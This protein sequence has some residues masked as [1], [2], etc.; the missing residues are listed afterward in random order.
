MIKDPNILLCM[1]NT[2]L[3]DFYESLDDL[4][5]DLN[6][7]KNDIIDLL[8]T[9]HYQY[10]EKLNAFVSIEIEQKEFPH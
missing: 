6:I 1:I 9:I 8:K 4:C 7:N 10:D 5:S 2:K 3:R